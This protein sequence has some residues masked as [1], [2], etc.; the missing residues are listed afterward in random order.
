M[1]PIRGSSAY[2]MQSSSASPA[3]AA[4]AAAGAHPS[5]H[6]DSLMAHMLSDH[7]VAA[8]NAKETQ[9]N[10]REKML[11]GFA[12]QALSSSSQLKLSPNQPADGD[13]QFG[14]RR[15]QDVLVIK[16]RLNEN[17]RS[18]YDVLSVGFRRGSEGSISMGL[19]VPAPIQS[20]FLERMPKELIHMT[21]DN[22]PNGG[23]K[24]R[25]TSLALSSKSLY[26]LG[27]EKTLAKAKCSALLDRLTAIKSIP[28]DQGPDGWGGARLVEFKAVLGS[29]Y[30]FRGK[31]KM[32][33]ISGLA[34][35]IDNLNFKSGD[36]FKLMLDLVESL[37][38]SKILKSVD[39]EHQ[40]AQIRDLNKTV[41]NLV[42]ALARVGTGSNVSAQDRPE[43]FEKLCSALEGL[44]G[45]NGANHAAA[46]LPNLAGWYAWHSETLGPERFGKLIELADRNKLYTNN[47]FK[48]EMVISLTSKRAQHDKAED[49]ANHFNVL[50][51]ISKTIEKDETKSD[52]MTYLTERL[53]WIDD[54]ALRKISKNHIADAVGTINNPV[55]KALVAAV[56][57]VPQ[58]D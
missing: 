35:E 47:E 16:A 4:Q 5:G 37:S 33:L 24:S 57:P 7:T 21:L 48:S 58:D 19:S 34:E 49:I 52:V 40:A 18:K 30:E 54:E 22:V 3:Q 6:A 39:P 29:L 45:E 51:G 26:A 32:D 17:D 25:V 46:A 20:S 11:A 10:E 50:C 14:I 15:N 2:N 1:D 28:A 12:K 8:L 43:V 55:L 41:A 13:A 44:E 27:L 38:R 23:S 56:T 9:G 53:N 31:E 36:G 42:S